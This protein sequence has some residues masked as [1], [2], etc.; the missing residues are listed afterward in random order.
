MTDTASPAL[1][2]PKPQRR[3]LDL[4][5]SLVVG[6]VLTVG[7]LVVALVSYFWL[8][9][10]PNIPNIKA[11]MTPPFSPEHWLGTEL[12]PRGEISHVWPADKPRWAGRLAR[13][14]AIPPEMVAGVGDSRG[15]IP[16]LLGVRHPFF[17][18][19]AIPAGL[20][21]AEH[22]PDGDILRIAELIIER[23]A[24]R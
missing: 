13:E 5:A 10:N 14:H 20:A 2:A 23:C 8:P 6:L 11:R 3:R 16:L 17:V 18:G 24:L 9:S 15:D 19:S 21:G 22:M 1:T 7:F 12:G 4:N